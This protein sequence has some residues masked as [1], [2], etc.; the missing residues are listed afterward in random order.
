MIGV[1]NPEYNYEPSKEYP[2]GSISFDAY[3]DDIMYQKYLNTFEPVV[4]KQSKDGTYCWLIDYLI[5]CI[6][7]IPPKDWNK[8]LSYHERKRLREQEEQRKKMEQ[9][10]DKW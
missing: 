10:K 7:D 8:G 5:A 4:Q 6:A 2:I 9:Q 3:L 1:E